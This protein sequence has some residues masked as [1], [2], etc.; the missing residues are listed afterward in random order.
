M[1]FDASQVFELAATFNAGAASV[2]PLAAVAVA[3]TAAEVKKDAKLIARQKGVYDTGNLIGSIGN[4]K[5]SSLEHTVSPTANYGIFHEVGT[6]TMPARPYLG[7]AL[8][9]Q[10]PNFLDAMSQVAGRAAGGGN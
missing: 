1:S 3:K 5:V 4:T 8:D 10:T 6:S 7:P 2:E 9:R